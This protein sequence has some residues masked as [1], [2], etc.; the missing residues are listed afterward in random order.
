PVRAARAAPG[1]GGHPRGRAGA[2]GESS[3]NRA[4]TSGTAADTPG[5]GAEAPGDRGGH[6]RGRAA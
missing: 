4:D 5:T 1:P 2:S 6:P 3:R